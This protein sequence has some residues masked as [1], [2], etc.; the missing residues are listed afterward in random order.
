MEVRLLHR[1]WLPCRPPRRTTERNAFFAQPRRPPSRAARPKER[2]M[3]RSLLGNGSKEV[4]E[5]QSVLGSMQ[6]A[7]GRFEELTKRADLSAERLRQLDAPLEKAGN[8]IDALATRLSDLEGRF[9]GMVQLA[10]ML[11]DLEGRAAELAK[12][13][14]RAETRIANTTE[15]ADRVRSTF[16]GISHKVDLALELRDRLANFLE[17]E[18]P[19]QELRNHSDSIRAQVE[20]TSEQLSRAREQQERHI[21]AQK[22]TTSKM[23]AMDR[24]RDELGRDLQDKERRLASVEQALRELDGVQDTVSNV[25]RDVDTLSAL[26]NVVGQKIAAL[27]PQREA[28]EAALARAEHLERAMRQID[29]GVRQQ[30]QNESMLGTMQDQVAAL[31]SLHEMVV[32]RSEE[33]AQ[34]QR[35]TDQRAQAIRGDLALARDEMKNAVERFEF[36]T[37]GLE[38]VS[39]RVTDVRGALTDFENRFKALGESS[40]AIEELKSQTQVLTSQLRLAS[41]ELGR[42]GQDTKQLQAMRRELD[43]AH[44]TSQDIGVQVGRPEATRPAPRS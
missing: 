23:E 43:D 28:V 39:Q 33:M 38:S 29:A 25:R 32:E 19:F 13:Q 41:E 9:E 44:R 8:N 18:K 21:D 2:S 4:A 36:E 16:E 30:Q 7:I 22:L 31:R 17:V 5:M 3:L 34:L 37:R 11:E 6:E 42:V 26:G 12:S 1:D 10:K 27:E 14:Q 35:E 20:A 15:N 40:H 24:R